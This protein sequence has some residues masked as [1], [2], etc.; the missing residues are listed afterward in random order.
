MSEINLKLLASQMCKFRLS[1]LQALSKKKNILLAARRELYFLLFSISSDLIVS[2]CNTLD[3]L[4]CDRGLETGL[5]GEQQLAKNPR[6]V[7]RSIKYF[8]SFEQH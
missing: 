8:F 2:C 6:M 4:N 1:L 3:V 7:V 5:S